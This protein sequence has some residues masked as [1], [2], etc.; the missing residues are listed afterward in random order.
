MTSSTRFSV[1]GKM[2]PLKGLVLTAL[3]SLFSK[4]ALG[5]FFSL[6]DD[7]SGYTFWVPPP[8]DSLSDACTKT[9]N[10]TI[11]CYDILPGIADQGVF[12][13]TDDLYA[14]CTTSCLQ[15]LET[16]RSSQVSACRD[17]QLFLN[18]ATYPALYV[19]DSFIYTYNYTC[20]TDQ[21]YSP[22]LHLEHI[23]DACLG[24]PLRSALHRSMHGET[25]P[26]H[27]RL[28]LAAPIAF[29]ALFSIS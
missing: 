6:G 8:S 25:R 11:A 10:S 3:I 24:L 12:P 7:D 21:L 28:S 13:E 15:S 16:F 2:A 22:S 9:F 17:D 26:I 23:T 14:L 29:W 1:S 5:Q 20:R 18:G 4:S 27:Q 19:I